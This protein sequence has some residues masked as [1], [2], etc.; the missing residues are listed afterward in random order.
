MIIV[1]WLT[2]V[3]TMA[4]IAYLS[5]LI[6]TN[7]GHHKCRE[8]W[9]S[10]TMERVYNIFLDLFLLVLPLVGL[11]ATYALIIHTLWKGMNLQNTGQVIATTEILRPT[12]SM[13]IKSSTVSG[14]NSF[15]SSC[16]WSDPQDSMR[17]SITAKVLTKKKRVVKM[18]FAVVAEFFICWTPLYVINTVALF[19]PAFVYNS[20]GFETISYFQLLAYSSS[21]CNPITYCFM[22]SSF[23]KAFLK[24]FKCHRSER[25]KR[26]F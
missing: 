24:L 13:K 20:L 15:T 23:R 9:P 16:H 19:A 5:Q 14:P 7:Q 17:R 26:T 10:R 11:M 22:N 18:L 25:A 8:I 4:P 2:S 12:S 21:C 6:P 1:I 3:F